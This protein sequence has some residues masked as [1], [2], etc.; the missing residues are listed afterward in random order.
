[1]YAVGFMQMTPQ[2]FLN[3]K[4]KSVDHLPW[5]ALIYKAMNTFIDDLFAFVI[6]MPGL[7]RLSVFRDDV[8]FFIYLYQRYI[9]TK[10][11]PAPGTAKSKA[12]DKELRAK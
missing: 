10:R 6:K 9:Y 8:V 11:R 3:Y 7:H 5:N 2:L 1:M 4:Y 12:K